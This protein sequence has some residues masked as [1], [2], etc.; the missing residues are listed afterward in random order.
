M[1]RKLPP[2]K[3]TEPAASSDSMEEWSP[4]STRRRR[5]MRRRTHRKAVCSLGCSAWRGVPTIDPTSRSNLVVHDKHEELHNDIQQKDHSV[6][7][8]R[9]ELGIRRQLL[10]TT[11]ISH[12]HPKNYRLTYGRVIF[13]ITYMMPKCTINCKD[14]VAKIDPEN[15]FDGGCSGD[16]TLS[17]FD[18]EMKKKIPA[19]NTPEM[20][21]WLPRNPRQI[22][23][24]PVLHAVHVQNGHGISPN[25]TVEREN[26]VDLE[27]RDQ[28]AAAKA[29]NLKN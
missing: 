24:I 5:W 21:I 6:Q 14:I 13:R 27:G 23:Q 18:D 11:K 1:E 17:G 20:V 22:V 3:G 28:R 19:I 12:K 26:D 4:A 2:A 16:S 25:K 7:H 8:I 29:Q 9:Y 15:S 10:R